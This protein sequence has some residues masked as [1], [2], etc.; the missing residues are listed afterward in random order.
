MA[1][2]VICG[3]E[4]LGFGKKPAEE[5]GY[6]EES[7]LPEE[8]PTVKHLYVSAV[9]F[10]DGFDWRS[11]KVHSS[12]N[13]SI[14]LY[15]DGVKT[16]TIPAGDDNEICDDVD[17]HHL[18]GGHIYSEY[19]SQSETIIKKDGKEFIRY[20][21][22]ETLK[23]M[24][25]KDG[26]LYTLGQ[27]KSGKGFSLRKNGEIVFQTDDGLIHGD[28]YDY[29]F[30]PTGALYL[31]GSTLC[32]AYY[33]GS[34]QTLRDRRD[35]YVVKDGV[36]GQLNLSSKVT[37]VY[38][39][40]VIGGKICFV[41]CEDYH[42]APVLTEGDTRIN[43][44]DSTHGLSRDYRLLRDGEHMLVSGTIRYSSGKDADTGIWDIHGLRETLPGT[45]LMIFVDQGS[46]AYVR[47]SGNMV[48]AYTEDVDET[49][50]ERCQLLLS[51]NVCYNDGHLY[52][53]ITPPDR[54]DNPHLITDGDQDDYAMNGYLSSV[55]IAY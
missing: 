44:Y 43:C 14:V 52:L 13:G 28:M 2:S 37:D 49:Q 40:K 31:D 23:G 9:E 20:S 53:A 25:L 12:D 38:D 48:S 54:Y 10:P 34:D 11:N 6:E 32:F 36:P 39:V 51:R 3:C 22:C 42:I 8:K 19:C 29:S 35:W 46:L 33:T 16:L 7:S 30:A 47:K 4:P 50:P 45:G 24:V 15:K 5:S 21:A 41:A 1:L 26:V 17:M 55:E 27:N 18:M